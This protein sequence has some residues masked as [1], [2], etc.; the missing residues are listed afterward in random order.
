MLLE[1]FCNRCRRDYAIDL[2]ACLEAFLKLVGTPVEGFLQTILQTTK[3]QE[4]YLEERL[5]SDLEES[6]N[7]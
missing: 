3:N 4:A 5:H 6:Y 2:E 7:Q 1:A